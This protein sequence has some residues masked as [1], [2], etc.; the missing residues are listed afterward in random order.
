MRKIE[1]QMNAAIT[2]KIDWASANTRV[3]YEQGNCVSRVYLHGNLIAEVGDNFVRLFDGGFQSNTTKS[4][5]NAILQGHG[6][7][8][9]CVF[10][11]Q[12]TWFVNL[13]TGNGIATVPFFSSMRL[14]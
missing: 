4:R 14:A 11:K 6:L 10:Q 12:W 13:K 9:E 3:E 7:P 5:L 2:N 8:G 1:R